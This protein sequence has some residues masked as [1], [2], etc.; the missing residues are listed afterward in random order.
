MI[1]HDTILFNAIY[2]YYMIGCDTIQCYAIHCKVMPM[3]CNVMR[4][5]TEYNTIQLKIQ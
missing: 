5:N 3:Q 4:C 1:R 2:K